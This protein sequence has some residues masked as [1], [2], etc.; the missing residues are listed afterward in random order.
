MTMTQSEYL[1]EVLE[2]YRMSHVQSF[3]NKHFDKRQEIKEALEN[4][5][6]SSI[7][8]PKN[9]GS[10]AKHTAIN[11][12]FDL[13]VM[14]PFKRN[15]FSTLEDMFQDILDFLKDKYRYEATVKD[16]NVS[17]GIDFHAD[18]DG[19]VVSIDIVPGRELNLNQYPLDKKLNL[20]I[21][22][23]GNR[24]D[25]QSYIQTNIHA[26]ID[27]IKSKEN[28][29]K[30]IRLLKIWKTTN[31]EKYKSFL[32]ELITIK[33]FENTDTS[34]NLWDK[35]KAV[36][37]YIRD[38]VNQDN[39]TLKD[40]GNSGN[41]VIDTLSRYERNQ[42]SSRMETI[43]NSIYRDANNLKVYFPKNTNG[44]GFKS[45]TSGPSRPPKNERFG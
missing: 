5:Y 1:Q 16:Q 33:S 7:Y 9:S 13:D 10:Y 27:H 34:G 38:N 22:S 39:F 23:R 29:R 25:S 2:T 42:L 41:N 12:K 19:E 6:T 14:V 8:P 26:Q 44:Y 37:K 35:L 4:H 36:M 3:V 40:P 24:A 20:N 43:L 11:K 28:E 32:L 21:N 17:I 31:N 30:I 45:N 15:A 18:S